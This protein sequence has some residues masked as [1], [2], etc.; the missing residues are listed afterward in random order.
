M[1]NKDNGWQVSIKSLYTTMVLG[2][3]LL[4]I[5]GLVG[6][7]AFFGFPEEQ[8]RTALELQRSYESLAEV[9]HINREFLANQT[10][11]YAEWDDTYDFIMGF[12]TEFL[13][14][15]FQP[16][17]F[18]LLKL[19]HVFVLDQSQAIRAG[20]LFDSDTGVLSEVTEL[21][22]GLDN[23]VLGLLLQDTTESSFELID[24]QPSMVAANPVT[25]SDGEQPG[26]GWLIF[27]SAITDD[28]LATAERI[29]Q[30]E[31]A[32]VTNAGSHHNVL[33]APVSTPSQRTIR[34]LD[35]GPVENVVCLDIDAPN[36]EMPVLLNQ[37]LWKE[38]I[39]L[40]VLPALL[41]AAILR[42]IHSPLQRAQDHLQATVESGRMHH[43]PIS[44]HL[45]I[46]E[47]VK[48]ARSHNR[49]V[50]TIMMQ[51]AQLKELSR[52]DALTSILNR[53]GFDHR[54]SECWSRL[55]RNRLSMALLMV[56]I[57]HFKRYND[58][59]GHPT[60]DMALQQVASTLAQFGKRT[61][62]T[63]A[64]YGG[65]EF[66]L[67]VY[68]Q[69]RDELDQLLKMVHQR[70]HQLAIPHIMSSVSEI[71][72]VSIG[73]AWLV[74]S[75]DWIH[76][77]NMSDWLKQADEALYEAKENGR[78]QSRVVELTKASFSISR[79]QTSSEA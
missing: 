11:D 78:S 16:E 20:Y 63:V 66:A 53:R 35:S 54:L 23:N 68:A 37:N 50:D 70:I 18:E 69:S 36:I 9:I 76:S 12:H 51:N 72:T 75:G 13:E 14:A 44:E 6:Y 21:P 43:I 15:N 38:F 59:Y 49:M 58:H 60:G 33:K 71:L 57:D 73:A 77:R 55:G 47:L 24:G 27:I 34:C 61:D 41:F 32:V 30:L 48:L 67:M 74:D 8:R 46:K 7:R 5:V 10:T 62:E 65:E 19:N 40:G 45:R 22:K 3:L 25:R 56:D 64:R 52:T 1:I 4:W 2:Y 17:T 39:L 26:I 28:T 79:S 42:M 31:L 29:T